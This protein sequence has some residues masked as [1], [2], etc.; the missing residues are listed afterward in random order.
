MHTI[1]NNSD[2]YVT[3][4]APNTPMVTLGM[5]LCRHTWRPAAGPPRP[6]T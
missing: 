4:R 1:V 3:S 2:V 6:C 5:L